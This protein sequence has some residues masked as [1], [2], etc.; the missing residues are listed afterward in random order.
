MLKGYHDGTTPKTYSLS[1]ESSPQQLTEQICIFD[2]IQ[3]GVDS[4][5]KLITCYYYKQAGE[6]PRRR[7]FQIVH[8]HPAGAHN[9]VG[10]GDH[11][12]GQDRWHSPGL[13]G[14]RIHSPPL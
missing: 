6:E 9:A 1:V 12:L 5:C 8:I 3:Y 4:L 14:D 13:E 7:C 11:T 10:V 2:D